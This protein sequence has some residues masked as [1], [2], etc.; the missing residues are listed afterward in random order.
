MSRRRVPLTE[1]A[2]NAV[3][4]WVASLLYSCVAFA[5]APGG[6]SNSTVAVPFE[7]D[8]SVL[9]FLDGA[10]LHGELQGMDTALGIQWSYPMA[11]KAIRFKPG[12]VARIKFGKAQPLQVHSQPTSRVLFKNG[13]E[14]L[15]DLGFV[16]EEKARLGTWFGGELEAPRENLRSITFFAKGYKVIYEGPN[17][18]DGWKLQKG[19]R[20]WQYKDGAFVADGVGILGRDLQLSDSSALAFDLAWSGRFSLS[21]IIYTEAIDRFDYSIN[22]YM[23]HLAP[24]YVSL[25]RVQVGAGVISIGPQTQIPD[26]ISKSKSRVKILVNK[27]EATIALWMDGVLVHRWKDPAGFVA[28]GSGVVFSSQMDGPTLRVSNV[29]VTQ[30]EG[31]FD[32]QDPPI[33]PLKEDLIYLVNSDQVSGTVE[34]IRDG[35]L[36]VGVRQTKLDIPLPRVT[37]VYFAQDSP[38]IVEAPPWDIRVDVA[39][40]GVVGFELEKW[41]NGRVS[42]QSANFG[43]VVIK[44]ESIRQVQFNQSKSQFLGEMSASNEEIWDFEE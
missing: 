29:Q 7:E 20:G 22:S 17:G 5:A 31:T 4:L 37:Q 42:G 32:I 40:G 15:G 10:F 36:R 18:V 28:R 23:F 14:I 24:G 2:G 43:L 39:G 16:D 11:K 44:P 26:M 41:D 3:L 27:A 12:G 35:K 6:V 9:Q 30:W 38:S 21:F 1:T 34:G 25:Q 8:S 19:S 33:E 13:D